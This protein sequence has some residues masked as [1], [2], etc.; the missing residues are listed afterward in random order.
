MKKTT[1]KVLAI[2]LLTLSGLVANAQFGCSS[3]IVLTN[4]FTQS[5]IT[6][7]GNGG[8]EDWNANPT[9]TSINA[10]YFND[11]VYLFTYTAGSSPES[12]SLTTYSRNSWNGLGIFTACNGNTFSGHL[13]SQASQ[14]E[15]ATK[16]VSAN[17]AAGQTIYIATGQWGAPNGLDFDVV[18]FTA[19]GLQA[20]SCG[21]FTSPTNNAVNFSSD[22]V[23][24]W[25]AVATATGYYLNVGTTSGGSDVLNQF[26]AGNV[27]TYN[28]PGNLSANTVY[29]ATLKPY[30]ATGS[31]T[32]CTEVMF[33][34]DSPPANDDCSNAIMLTVNSSLQCTVV[35][36]GTTVGATQSQAA[37]PCYGTPNDD[38]WFK[39][40]ATSTS[41]IVSITN[42]VAVS[43][44]STDMYFQIFSGACATLQSVL[45][46]DDESNTVS[47][48]VVGNTYL[49]RVYSYYTTSRQTFNICIGSQP[50]PPSNDDCAG[51]INLPVNSG[52]SCTN[53]ISGTTA[54][55]TL[56]MAAT[57]C[58]GNPDDD[59]WF[60]F[61]ATSTS[62]IITLSNIVAVI[63][64]ST[65]MYF[66]VLSGTCGNTTSKLCSDP[67]SNTVAALIIGDTYFV[68]VYSYSASSRQ[69]FDICI[70]TSPAPPA[71]DNCSGSVVL[72]V[73]PTLD[74]TA[75]TSATTA[76][77]TSSM[78]AGPCY[79]NPNDDVWFSF[80]ATAPSHN[81]TLSN[82]TAVSGTSTDMYLQVLSGTCASQT[83]LLCSDDDFT[84]VSGLTVGQVYYVRV[85]T[86][87][88]TSIVN[89]NICIATDPQL[90]S[91]AFSTGKFTYYPNPTKDQLRITHSSTINNVAIYN[92]MGQQVLKIKTNAAEVSVDMSSLPAGHYVVKAIADYGADTFKVV[93]K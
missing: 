6:T 38:V 9:D 48:L 18:S 61:V 57:P 49:M 72:T 43:G 71:N 34:T 86:Y 12:I 30:N 25:P 8:P 78:T 67:N 2:A 55:A 90:A 29:Y 7:P 15:N 64:T 26:D 63:G 65:D 19:G 92:M 44:V 68:R 14:G 32:G 20:P 5:G 31:A 36:A 75:T 27:T 88:A 51:A 59:V 77:A 79:G 47:G 56:S 54:G 40:V 41:H 16:T 89:F 53:V 70:S 42:I 62:H 50:A 46:S 22:G 83:S 23:F 33:T 81:I 21:S 76:G 60:K 24:T 4:G 58:T 52:L 37:T 28:I 10:L 74:C 85:Y 87:F 39:F 45:C 91:P 84:T 11:D 17:I 69:N 3:A 80:I 73:N 35:T 13:S 82:I 93:K 66:Q 1:F